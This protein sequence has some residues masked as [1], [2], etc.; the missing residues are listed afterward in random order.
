[1][2]L[3]VTMYLQ[4]VAVEQSAAER[5]QLCA[6]LA[7]QRGVSADLAQCVSLTEVGTKYC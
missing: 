5:A 6:G 4:P 2:C 7:A 1:M 3:L